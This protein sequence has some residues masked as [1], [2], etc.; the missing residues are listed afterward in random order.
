MV[1]I[2]DA[3]VAKLKK[4]NHNFE[5]LVDC[6]L[7]M[8]F[9]HGEDVQINDV[10]AVGNI[11]KDAR[12]G[13]IAP[14]LKEVFGTENI[15]D[16]A[17]QILQK[18]EIHLTSDYRKKL[19]KEKEEKIIGMI[20]RNGM[21]PRTKAPIPSTRVELALEQA[22][23]HID[24]FKPA[25]VQMEEIIDKLRPVLP[26]SFEKKKFDVLVPAQFA[27]TAYGIIKKYGK[28]LKEQWTQTGGLKAVV[29]MP[30]GMSEEFVDK[31]NKLTHGDVQ[32]MEEK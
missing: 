31:L 3:V 10:L 7:A 14:D 16:I 17:K 29:E 1:R 26:I 13:D 4:D 23:V 8:K 12:K 9:K 5:I 32:V 11:F 22:H 30:A 21:D 6:E 18:G 15:E 24:P 25:E 28:I 2:E 19:I 27:S 20:T